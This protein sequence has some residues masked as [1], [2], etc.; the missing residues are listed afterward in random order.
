MLTKP[1]LSEDIASRCQM[2][3]PATVVLSTLFWVVGC[4]QFPGPPEPTEPEL[5]QTCFRLRPPQIDSV[6]PPANSTITPPA[7]IAIE[8]SWHKAALRNLVID[9]WDVTEQIWLEPGRLECTE[10]VPPQP[11]YAYL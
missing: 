6:S 3:F 8:I 11:L 1:W 7:P 2:H 5:P 10:D 4:S 9:G